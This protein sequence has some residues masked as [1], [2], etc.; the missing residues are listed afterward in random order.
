MYQT[1]ILTENYDR[2]FRIYT[3]GQF[4][5][6]NDCVIPILPI[7]IAPIMT[8]IYQYLIIRIY[9]TGKSLIGYYLWTRHTMEHFPIIRHRSS[10][11]DSRDLRTGG[12]AESSSNS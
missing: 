2:F 9:F 10:L 11:S 6:D 3:L 5:K 12:S 4:V 8:K 7:H 1:K